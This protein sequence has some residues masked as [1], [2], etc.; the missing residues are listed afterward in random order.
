M[1][2]DAPFVWGWDFWLSSP[3]ISA[4]FVYVGGGDGKVYALDAAS[5]RSLWQS[6]TGG[7]VR[8]SPAVLDGAVYVGSMDGRLY[9]L[10]AA[11]GQSRWIFD[12]E[13][14]TIDSRKAGFDRTSIVSSPAVT[15]QQVFVGSRDAHLYAV[16]RRTGRQ[17]WRFG[18]KM[19]SMEGSPE[20]SWV[21]GSPAVLDGRVLVGSSDGRFFDAVDIQSG[22]EVWRFKTPRNVLSSAALAGGQAFF[23]CDD[24]HVF[25][26]DVRTGAERWRFRT[27][28]AVMS[29][30]A[31]AGGVVLV[32]SDD[33]VVYALRTGVE[34]PGGRP[35]RAVYWKDLG[36]R[37]W[38]QGDVAVR[39][40]LREEGY[41]VL[42]ESGLAQFLAD[43][44]GAPRTVVVMATGVLPQAA[45]AP[46][47]D[48][49]PLRGYLAAGGRM[50]WLGL[51]PD[52]IELDP[53]TGDPVGF[54]LSRSTRLLGVAHEGSNPEAMGVAAT[55]DGRRWG[56]PEW[57]LGGFPVASDDV[58]QVL[59][60]NELGQASAWVKSYGGPPGS[61]F[62]RVWG[63]ESPI[64]DLAWVRAVAEH[65]E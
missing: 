52:S 46:S 39:D 48:R 34:P 44:A 5:G 42:D 12:T 45:L 1:G 59:G 14:H 31:V 33:G 7:R 26:L 64:P 53:K 22:E 9:A 28:G 18:H 56:L 15:T 60:W 6:S 36:P 13:G 65:V 49:S 8:S 37:K 57:W 41:E 3:V 30:P 19:E 47:G 4:G 25:A 24:G 38:F 11:T 61:G 51:P 55:A 16:D 35:R 20:V 40:Y 27:G 10:D 32:G 62:V 43:T 17:L 23:G 21:I 29:S 2:R 54:D 58:T 50:V 63:Q